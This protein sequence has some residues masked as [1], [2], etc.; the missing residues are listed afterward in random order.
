MGSVPDEMNLLMSFKC[1]KQLGFQSYF[2]RCVLQNFI[3]DISSK[4]LL[5]KLNKEDYDALISPT[6]KICYHQYKKLS[7]SYSVQSITENF[8]IELIVHCFYDV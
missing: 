4:F 5:E 8:P 2:K 7:F 6:L 3:I 1:I